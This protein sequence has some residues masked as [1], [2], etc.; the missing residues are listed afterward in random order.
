MEE[1]GATMTDMLSLLLHEARAGRLEDSEDRTGVPQPLRGSGEK[2]LVA[3]EFL[4][5]QSKGSGCG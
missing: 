3:A 2:V 4:S 1:V 5:E